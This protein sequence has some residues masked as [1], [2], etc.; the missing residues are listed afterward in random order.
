MSIFQIIAIF[1]A[2]FMMYVTRIHKKQLAFSLAETLLWYSL[3]IVF[4]A[5][6]LFPNLLTGITDLLHF[7]RVFDLLI[8]GALMLLTVIVVLTNFNQRADSKRIERFVREHAIKN[9]HKKSK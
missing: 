6:A 9:A 4:A 8:V 2:L 7:A 5:L 1:F 3:W